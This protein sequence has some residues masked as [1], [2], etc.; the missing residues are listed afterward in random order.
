MGI[1][2]GLSVALAMSC[3]QPMHYHH[4]LDMMT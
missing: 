3:M 1:V 4:K 2:E